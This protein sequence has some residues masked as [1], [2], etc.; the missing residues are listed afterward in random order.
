MLPSISIGADRNSQQPSPKI[1]PTTLAHSVSQAKDLHGSVQTTDGYGLSCGI[2]GFLRSR[3]RPFRIDSSRER[4][5]QQQYGEIKD[6][7]G[8]TG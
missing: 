6:E 8:V 3:G 4:A 5:E 2:A 7:Q 1:T